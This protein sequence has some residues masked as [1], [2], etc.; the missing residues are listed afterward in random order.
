M[1]SLDE[2]ERI[3]TLLPKLTEAE[4]KDLQDWERKHVTGDGKFSSS[5]WPEWP[6]VI[7]RLQN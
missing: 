4:R 6:A 1:P 7:K 3:A 2:F 5:D